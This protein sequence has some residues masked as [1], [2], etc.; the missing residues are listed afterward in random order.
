[1]LSAETRQLCNRF[2]DVIDYPDASLGD[3]AAA[4][5][6][7]LDGVSGSAAPMRTFAAF[8]RDRSTA[9]MEEL[10][11]Q[12]F[13]MSA[14]TTLHIGYHIFGETPKRSA[15]LVKLEEAFKADGFSSGSELADHLCV[16]LRFFNV[17]SDP[18]FVAPLVD[19]CVLP[20][21]ETMEKALPEKKT[22]YRPAVRSLRLF[23]QH[24]H[25][26]LEKE[27]GPRDG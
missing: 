24:L 14:A 13:D 6:D 16:L 15:F 5:L 11:T 17:A 20:V 3:T 22:G 7:L 18:E 10:Y 19:E 12:T 25:R 8:A 27:G 4:C 23:M 21:L 2:A 26:A 9:E 1:M